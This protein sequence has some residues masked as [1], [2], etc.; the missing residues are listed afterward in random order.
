[1][2]KVIKVAVKA[3]IE[4]KKKKTK[5]IREMVHALNNFSYSHP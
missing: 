3:K 1:M 4:K 2:K 5:N